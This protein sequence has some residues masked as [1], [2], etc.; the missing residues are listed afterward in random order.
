LTHSVQEEWGER[1][2][3]GVGGEGGKREGRKDGERKEV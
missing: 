2:K 3:E 1:R